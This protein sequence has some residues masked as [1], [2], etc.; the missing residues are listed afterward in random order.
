MRYRAQLDIP[1]VGRNHILKFFLVLVR[2]I[3]SVQEIY[4]DTL[5]HLKLQS[6]D[7]YW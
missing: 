7:K 6:S 4:S 3:I 2:K 1:D 5:F